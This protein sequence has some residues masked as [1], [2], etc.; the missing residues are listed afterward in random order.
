MRH[1][2]TGRSRA[3]LYHTGKS[4]A[5]L[6]HTGRERGIPRVVPGEGY[7]QGGTGRI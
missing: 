7:T 1:I 6:Y 4:R 3:V 2:N 5:V